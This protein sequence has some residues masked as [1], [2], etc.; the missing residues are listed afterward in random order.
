MP[1][2]SLSYQPITRRK[3]H[4]PFGGSR[5]TWPK[6]WLSTNVTFV[7]SDFFLFFS[8]RP[9]LSIQTRRSVQ[10]YVCTVKTSRSRCADV[11]AVVLDTA[12]VHSSASFGPKV[13]TVKTRRSRCADVVAVLDTALVHSS[14]SFG[15]KV[16][17]YRKDSTIA[18]R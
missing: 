14:A 9:H 16:C 11:V 7:M 4:S 3:S 12:L 13:H 10:R 17:M 18:L 1:S 15:P 8:F 5:R 2:L 6:P